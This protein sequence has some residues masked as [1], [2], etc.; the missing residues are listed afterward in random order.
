MISAHFVLGAVLLHG[1]SNVR[2]PAQSGIANGLLARTAPKRCLCPA[3]LEC[4]QCVQ[5]QKFTTKN[6][7]GRLRARCCPFKIEVESDRLWQ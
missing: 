4:R 3:G 2:F 1:G 7:E 5:K 6:R